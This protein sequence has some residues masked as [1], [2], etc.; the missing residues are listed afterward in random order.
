[1]DVKGFGNGSFNR[2]IL[3]TAFA[4]FLASACGSDSGDGSEDGNGTVNQATSPFDI[5]DQDS[6]SGPSTAGPMPANDDQVAQPSVSTPEANP[7]PSPESTPAPSSSSGSTL[8]DSVVG[9]E[10]VS[11]VT[12]EDFGSTDDIQISV[13]SIGFASFGTA[14]IVLRLDNNSS[15][16]IYNAN[17]AINALQGNR[18]LGTA[19]SFFASLDE[20]NPGEGAIDTG[21]W[22][23]L[24]SF[25]EFEVVS[26]SCD[27]ID[28]SPRSRIDI[29]TDPVN[30]SF[31][32]YTSSGENP[33]VRKPSVAT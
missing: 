33:A 10:L 24:D 26:F 27:W 12:F 28:G 13:A 1:M 22:F 30:I 16:P 14:Q 21:F 4:A 19:R 3:A 31:V 8:P 9:S 2:T 29:A 11:N 17:C 32:G 5:V 18:V 20:I 15:E 7:Q 25:S 23:G 6:S